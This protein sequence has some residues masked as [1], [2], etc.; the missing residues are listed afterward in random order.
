[1]SLKRSLEREKHLL[2]LLLNPNSLVLQLIKN[3]IN[4]DS[5]KKLK[6]LL[7]KS[8]FLHKSRHLSSIYVSMQLATYLPTI[9]SL[10]YLVIHFPAA[11][12]LGVLRMLSADGS[13]RKRQFTQDDIQFPAKIYKT[14]GRRKQRV[15]KSAP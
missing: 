5:L 2:V 15:G 8:R 3:I 7:H 6:R 4:F 1:M 9:P 13:R 14:M 11:W 12:R 10:R